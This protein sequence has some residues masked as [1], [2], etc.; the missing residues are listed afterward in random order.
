MSFKVFNNE[1]AISPGTA[2]L[3]LSAIAIIGAAVVGVMLGAFSDNI[4]SHVSTSD[5][6]DASATTIHIGGSTTCQPVITDLA[7]QYMKDHEGIRISVQGGGSGEGRVAVTM[8]TLN[9]G[10]SSDPIDAIQY[11]YLLPFQFGGSAVIPVINDISGVNYTTANDL[12]TLYQ[13]AN[14][15]GVVGAKINSG[16][17]QY[18]PSASFYL[19]VL[20][21]SDTS[22]TEETFSKYIGSGDKTWINNTNALNE[23]G[24]AGMLAAL[25]SATTPTLGFLGMGYAF[26]S[27]GKNAT[28]VTIIGIDSCPAANVTHAEVL[29]TLKAGTTQTFPLIL[30][31]GLYFCTRGPATTLEQDFMYYCISPQASTTYTKHGVYSI[32]TIKDGSEVSA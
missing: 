17:L 12:H 22:G 16:E 1:K 7:D 19:T 18:D 10:M 3:I 2:I 8:G 5:A 26:D 20:Q 4:A 15:S 29:K 6:S 11:P 30:T 32:I 14:S 24:N 31:R 28:G 23:V 21:R 25:Q 9:I 27:T 13:Y